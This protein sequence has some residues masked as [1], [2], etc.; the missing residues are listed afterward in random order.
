[1]RAWLS[2]AL[3]LPA[4]TPVYLRP[5]GLDFS[6]AYSGAARHAITVGF[7]SL[8][9][10]GVASKVVPTLNGIP[11]SVLPRLWAPFVLINAGCAIRV[12]FQ[13][14]TDFNPAAFRVA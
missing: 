1:A 12:L 14:L 6:H 5:V 11:A 13:A 7:V 9:I 3:G 10:V 4:F 2:G 8:M